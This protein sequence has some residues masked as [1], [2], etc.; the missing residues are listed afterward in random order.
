MVF[1]SH[2]ALLS[3]SRYCLDESVA[4]WGMIGRVDRNGRLD[5]VP[6][7]DL[8]DPPT[9]N[10]NI[11]ASITTPSTLPSGKASATVKAIA[12]PIDEPTK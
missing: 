8:A 12:P 2:S 10:D 4:E 6:N 1:L 7:A 5:N 11:G 9:F 3:G